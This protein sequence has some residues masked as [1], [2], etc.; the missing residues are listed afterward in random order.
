MSENQSRTL[1]IGK[2]TC[3]ANEYRCF[4]DFFMH[5][6]RVI[7]KQRLEKKTYKKRH[8]LSP[9]LMSGADKTKMNIEDIN[10]G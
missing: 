8:L 9:N 4:H 3:F 1:D 2:N 6:S 7:A 10:S 5:K